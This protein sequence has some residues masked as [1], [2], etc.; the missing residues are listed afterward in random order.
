MKKLL[1]L[2]AVLLTSVG[3]WAQTFALQKSTN[4][5][6]PEFQYVIQNANSEFMGPQTSPAD[7]ERGKFAFFAYGATENDVLVYS[8]NA[9]M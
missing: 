1:F 2:F 8:I 6:N 9:K 5:D 3:A 7:T 4:V